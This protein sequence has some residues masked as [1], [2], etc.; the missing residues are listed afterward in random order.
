MVFKCRE[1]NAA[2]K[3]CLTQ[4]WVLFVVSCH[5]VATAPRACL[6][7]SVEGP[8]N[9]HLRDDFVMNTLL[10]TFTFCL[11]PATRTLTFFRCVSRN[12]SRKKWSLRGPGS[13][14]KT[15]DKSSQQPCKH[16]RGCL[17]H[18]WKKTNTL[19]FSTE[20]QMCLGN[21]LLDVWEIFEPRYLLFLQENTSFHFWLLFFRSQNI[22]QIKSGFSYVSKKV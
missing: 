8:C 19:I 18:G 7:V 5:S 13:L 6:Q 20:M 15:D 1:E 9:H 22:Y 17:K 4:Q 16:N 12:T 3:D 21:K 2:L 10:V 14:Q 11:S